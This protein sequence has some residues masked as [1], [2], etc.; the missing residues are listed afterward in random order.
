MAR[1]RKLGLSW[2]AKD[3]LLVDDEPLETE[4][5]FLFTSEMMAS[6]RLDRLRTGILCRFPGNGTMP[7]DALQYAGR[8][9]KIRRGPAEPQDVYELRL[10]GAID[11]HR[12]RGNAWRMMEQIRAYCYPHAVR[13]RIWTDRGDVYTLDRD[14]TTDLVRATAWDWDGTFGVDGVWSRFWVLIYVTT[15]ATPQPWQRLTWGMPGLVW[16]GPYTWGSTAT[17]ADVQSIRSIVETWK[18][19]GTHCRHIMVVFNDAA[20][21]PADTAPPLPDGT[22]GPWTKPSGTTKVPTRSADAI[23]WPGTRGPSA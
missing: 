4:S 15:D 14:E 5:R 19:E 3:Q 13:V 23:Y 11:K 2:L 20:F 10:V 22:W 21:D 16:G 17:P 7:A 8:D 12:T 9:R 1:S 18:P 6:S